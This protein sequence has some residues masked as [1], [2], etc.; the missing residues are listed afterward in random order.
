MEAS[1]HAVNDEQMRWNREGG[2]V[3][4]ISLTVHSTQ[5]AK[6]DFNKLRVMKILMRMEKKHSHRPVI[7]SSCNMFTDIYRDSN[8]NGIK[9]FSNNFN[10]KQFL[11]SCL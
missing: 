7:D 5:P 2:L 4:Q 1:T 3:R 10:N 9:I 6:D 11:E 8:V